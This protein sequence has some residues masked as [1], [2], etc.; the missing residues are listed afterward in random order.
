MLLVVGSGLG[1]Q[2]LVMVDGIVAGR[3]TLTWKRSWCVF[4][5]L[6]FGAPGPTT[7]PMAWPAPE[8]NTRR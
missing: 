4:Q 1:G 8:A 6:G 7:I 3:S 5:A 2:L